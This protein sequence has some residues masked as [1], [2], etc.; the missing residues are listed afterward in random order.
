MSG[1]KLNN[2]FHWGFALILVTIFQVLTGTVVITA[3][4]FNSTLFAIFAGY[5][6][7]EWAYFIIASIF[8][9]R[10]TLSLR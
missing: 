1:E 3:N 2:K 8:A 4:G 5:I 9:D 6:L 10:I 7:L